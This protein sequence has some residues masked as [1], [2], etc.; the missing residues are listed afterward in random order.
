MR[1][2]M[3]IGQTL[4]TSERTDYGDRFPTTSSG[5]CPLVVSIERRDQATPRAFVSA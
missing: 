3:V 5:V 2:Q 1:C 4:V